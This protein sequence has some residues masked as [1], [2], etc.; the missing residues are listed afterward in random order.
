M[1]LGMLQIFGQYVWIVIIK[2]FSAVVIY[3]FLYLD[4][5]CTEPPPRYPAGTWEWSQDYQYG[6]QILY[7]CGPYG[8]FQSQ[9]G[10]LYKELVAECM[11][12][13]TWAPPELDICKGILIVSPLR[14]H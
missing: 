6:T 12:N 1:G 2:I 10:V 3:E 14:L 4:T 5:N 7:T 11:W 13:K 9:D 8:Q